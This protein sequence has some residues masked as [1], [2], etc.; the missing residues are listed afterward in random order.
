MNELDATLDSMSPEE[1]RALESEIDKKASETTVAYY[2]GLGAKAAREQ[3]AEFKK[4]GTLSPAL[5]LAKAAADKIQK[6]AEFSAALD[7]CSAEELAEI[8]A[9]LDTRILS[10]ISEEIAGSYYEQGKKLARSTH[11]S[12]RKE[13]RGPAAAGAFGALGKAIGAF[14]KQKPM[15]AGAALGV[16]GTLVAQKVLD[17]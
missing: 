13:A 8:E 16:G 2:L 5:F 7:K 14:A 3:Y 12:M 1:L 11:E 9:E 17:R 4:T 15:I 10:K 6:N